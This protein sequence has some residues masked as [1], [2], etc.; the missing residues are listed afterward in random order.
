MKKISLA[1]EAFIP[2]LSVSTSKKVF[3]QLT[4]PSGRIEPFSLDDSGS[5]NP[6]Q[7]SEPVE[8]P[9]RK[10]YLILSLKTLRRIVEVLEIHFRIWLRKIGKRPNKRI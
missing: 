10:Q 5:H 9:I 4:A 2:T 7:V 3:T 8:T 6:T 1:E